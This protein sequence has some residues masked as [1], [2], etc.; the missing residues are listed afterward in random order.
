GGGG[1]DFINGEND[2]DIIDGGGG[3][4]VIF[5]GPGADTLKGG[6]GNDELFAMTPSGSGEGMLQIVTGY[7]GLNDQAT[8]ATTHTGSVGYIGAAFKPDTLIGGGGND[9]LHSGYGIDTMTG[10]ADKDTFYFE[11]Q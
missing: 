6:E 7:N 11:Y 5:G 8:A 10:G 2:D 9:R 1:N 3:N 4:D